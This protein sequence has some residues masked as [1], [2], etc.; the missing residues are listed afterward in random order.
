MGS[1]LRNLVDGKPEESRADQV[2]K[3]DF[4]SLYNADLNQDFLLFA[5]EVL[6]YLVD[7]FDLSHSSK[8]D[9]GTFQAY[10]IIGKNIASRASTDGPLRSLTAGLATELGSNLDAFNASWQLHSGLGMEVLWTAFRP[11]SARNLNQ[12]ENSIQIKDLANRFD[13][14]R[15]GSGASVQELCSLQRSIARIHDAIGSASPLNVRSLEVRI[16]SLLLSR[17]IY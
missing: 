17:L 3:L 2:R 16:L 1:C 8:F 12:F 4:V 14:L 15:W 5:H 13:A 6:A 7:V 9:E 11:V 10:Q